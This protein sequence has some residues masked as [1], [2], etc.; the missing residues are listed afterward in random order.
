LGIS[1]LKRKLNSLKRLWNSFICFIASLLVF[2]GDKNSSAPNRSDFR[3][4]PEPYRPPEPNAPDILLND[5]SFSDG[6][7]RL[8]IFSMTGI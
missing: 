1:Y 7:K 8:P 6:K 4:T 3:V 2:G 5:S